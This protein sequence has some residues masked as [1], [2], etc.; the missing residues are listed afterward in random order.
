MRAQPPSVP[1]FTI[2]YGRFETQSMAQLHSIELHL[3]V[4]RA[5]ASERATS[6]LRPDLEN[7]ASHN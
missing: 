5:D 2:A 3:G 1:E 4:A 7:G 6:A